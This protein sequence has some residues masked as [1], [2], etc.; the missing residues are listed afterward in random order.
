M[1]NE[2]LTL[3]QVSQETYVSILQN[4][5]HNILV[6]ALLSERINRSQFGPIQHAPPLQPVSASN[7]TPTPGIKLE[8]ATPSTSAMNSRN[9]SPNTEL[10]TRTEYYNVPGRDVFGNEKIPDSARLFEC[11]NCQ[12]KIAGSRFAAHIDRCLG[13]RQRK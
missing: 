12:R 8:G 10:L 11:T 4:I 6:D 2:S 7:Q 3:L 13:G 1:S 5:T 9:N